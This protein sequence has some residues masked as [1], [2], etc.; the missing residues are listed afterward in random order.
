MQTYLT[1]H[2]AVVTDWDIVVFSLTILGVFLLIV[3]VF[4]GTMWIQRNQVCKSPY[5]GLPLRR[6]GDLPYDSKQKIL[7]FVYDLHQ[8]DNRIFS[9]KHSSL[10]RETGRIFPESVTWYGTIKVDW[11]FLQKRYSGTYV[12]WGSL[13]D[14]QQESIRSLHYSLDGYQTDFSSSNPSPRAIEPEYAYT[15]PGP[16]Y[17]DLTKNVLLGWKIVPDTDFEVLI[18]QLP[19]RQFK[20]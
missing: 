14:T 6:V 17:V 4:F 11:N 3:G 18:V 7:R 8:Y 13:T 1:T 9:L 19:K 16:L 5:S 12:S 20:Y 15:K 10:C 2:L